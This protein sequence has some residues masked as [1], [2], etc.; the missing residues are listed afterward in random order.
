MKT[1][2]ALMVTIVMIRPDR[3][4]SQYTCSWLLPQPAAR[5]RAAQRN[6]GWA[7]RIRINWQYASQCPM[8]PSCPAKHQGWRGSVFFHHRTA[9]DLAEV[10]SVSRPAVYR[11]LN[12]R[13]SPWRSIP[14]DT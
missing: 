1:T 3:A 9:S 12:R 11:T 10:C 6:G 13:L 14:P 2:L 4:H 5:R 7:H 8:K